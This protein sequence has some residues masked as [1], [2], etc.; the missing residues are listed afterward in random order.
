MCQAEA[1]LSQGEK[2]TLLNEH[3]YLRGQ[4]NPPA[5]NMKKMVSPYILREVYFG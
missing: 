3:N 4:V 2:D 1:A 5:T